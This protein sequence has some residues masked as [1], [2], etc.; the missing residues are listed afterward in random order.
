MMSR[1]MRITRRGFLR[2]TAA[3]TAV[4]PWVVSSRA[5]GA[6]D[7]ITMG[8]IGMGGRGTGDMRGFLGFSE[9]Q[10]LAVCD[11]IE[12]HRERAKALV[13][14]KYG[15][16]ACASYNDFR[17][18]I[19]RDDVDTVMIGTPDH[20]HAIISIAAM[21]S[22]KDV[23]CEKPETLT[24]REGRQMAITARRYGQ[25]FSGGSQRVWGDYNWFHKMI[26]GGAIGD[27]REAWVNVNGPSSPCDLPGEPIPPGVDWDLWLGP[28]PWEPY[29]KG[30]LR[31]RPWR[32]YSG[33]GMTD[34]GCHVFGGA[35]FALGLHETG[36]VE[37]IPPDGK[38]YP[39]LTYRFANGMRIYHGG[40]WGSRLSF[41][42]TEG[43]I[44]FGGGDRRNQ[45]APPNVYIPNYKGTGG[46]PGDFLHCVRTRQ[47]PFRS[48][49]RGHRAATVAHLGNIAYRLQRPL[50]WD[51]KAEQILGDPEAARL[52][53]RP[54]REPWSL[55]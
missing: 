26:A 37:V 46:L 3:V 54:K 31:F 44:P 38:D 22:G 18:I 5:F 21:R 23:F 4:A 33:G 51:P 6:N 53:D 45:P 19:A 8:C 32:D 36:P 17:E 30:R 42:G 12:S 11:V 20:W 27:V 47:E 25:V 39:R 29:N 52:L 40:G 43:Q 7:R 41:R 55:Y 49:E 1:S 14:A 13:D 34:W 35:L 24:V 10:V 16:A 48:I 2:K 28:A 50:K 9:V 15:N